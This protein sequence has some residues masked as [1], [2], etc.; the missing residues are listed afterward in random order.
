MLRVRNSM[1][2]FW[3][4]L[5]STNVPSTESISSYVC[6]KPIL[7]YVQFG[8]QSV[9]SSRW[10]TGV[11]K[12]RLQTACYMVQSVF[13]VFVPSKAVSQELFLHRAIIFRW[14]EACVSLPAHRFR[15]LPPHDGHRGR[16]LHQHEDMKR[17]TENSTER[18]DD[19]SQWRD[20]RMVLENKSLSAGPHDHHLQNAPPGTTSCHPKDT[21]LSSYAVFQREHVMQ[22]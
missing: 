8:P 11:C 14:P 7:R 17:R 21:A 22:W 5:T 6:S 13:S 3:F 9:Q 16:S 10:A 15:P 1:Q 20:T 12:K 19:D 2:S 4:S 18:H